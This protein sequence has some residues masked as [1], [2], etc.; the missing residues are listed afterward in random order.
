MSAQISSAPLLHIVDQHVDESAHLAHVRQVLV[1]SAHARLHDLLRHDQRLAAHLD[2]VAV[3]GGAGWQACERAVEAGTPGA[4]FA[5][6]VVAIES[7]SAA[8]IEQMLALA[9]ALPAVRRMVADAFGWVS[10]QWLAGL[11]REML[12]APSAVH[13]GLALLACAAHRV[14]PGQALAAALDD[15]D[16]GLRSCAL[17]CAGDVGRTDLRGACG[18]MARA[19]QGGAG[20]RFWAARAALLLGGRD[21]AL[22]ALQEMAAAPGPWRRPA[23]E[24][25]LKA[26]DVSQAAALLQPLRQAPGGERA[27]VRGI[28]VLGDPAFV[29]WLIER[30]DDPALARLAGESLAMITGCE[31]GHADL[32][33][34][35]PDG[36]L[37]VAPAVEDAAEDIVPLDEDEGLPLSDPRRVAAWWNRAGTRFAAGRR[38][39]MGAPVAHAHCGA[40]LL[41]GTQRQRGA[42][43][44]HLVLAEPGKPLFN[45]AAPA[46]RQQRWLGALGG[47]MP[48]RSE[49]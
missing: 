39:F 12:A 6:A 40:V 33:L 15:A 28:G 29:P 44:E 8:R 19:A 20:P 45:V 3:A 21:A 26:I 38:L 7:G 23:L 5:A 30:M 2:G 32:L 10:A 14:D 24:L 46:W 18:Q 36:E 11:I 17:R 47:V 9:Q 43:A 25:V 27:L 37:A 48:A 31:T 16:E 4:A 13:R 41:Q 42:A 49:A 34:R 1:D 22:P 35:T